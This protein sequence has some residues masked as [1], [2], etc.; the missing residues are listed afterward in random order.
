MFCAVLWAEEEEEWSPTRWGE[1]SSRRYGADRRRGLVWV[2]NSFWRTAVRQ[3]SSVAEQGRGVSIPS[4]SLRVAM[5]LDD[6]PKRRFFR[7][8]CLDRRAQ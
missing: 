6:A 5:N 4:E 3:A 2:E 8:A 7:P 1:C